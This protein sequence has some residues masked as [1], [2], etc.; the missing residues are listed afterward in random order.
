MDEQ[1]GKL[2]WRCRRGMKE[3]DLLTLA[4]LDRHYPT[5]PAEEQQA[6]AELLELQDPLLMSYMVGRE[7]PADAT[8]AKVVGVMRTLLNEAD[9]S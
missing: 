2:R 6:F 4:Y 5:A 7:T 3:L 8:T 9:G 1:I